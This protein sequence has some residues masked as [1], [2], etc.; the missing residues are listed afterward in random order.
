M[1]RQ[2]AVSPSP[3]PAPRCDDPNC[4]CRSPDLQWFT[5]QVL[6]RDANKTDYIVI[7]LVAG[8]LARCILGD[9]SDDSIDPEGVAVTRSAAT[10]VLELAERGRTDPW[11]NDP[12]AYGVIAT[13]VFCN[14]PSLLTWGGIS[15]HCTTLGVGF[16][17]PSDQRFAT[18]I[19]YLGAEPPPSLTETVMLAM[20]TAVREGRNKGEMP[21]LGKGGRRL[22]VI[23]AD[24]I[25]RQ[26]LAAWPE[27]L[28]AAVDDWTLP[29]L[30]RLALHNGM[31]GDAAIHYAM[32]QMARAAEGDAEEASLPPAPPH[33]VEVSGEAAAAESLVNEAV[34]EIKR[35]HDQHAA[36]QRERDTIAQRD[37]RLR[38]RLESLEQQL[39]DEREQ[40]QALERENA[41]LRDERDWFAERVAVEPALLDE[42]QPPPADAFSGRR[43]LFF[44][45]VEAGDARMA[46]AQGFWDLGA[47]QVDVY[48]TDK[49]RGP[50]AFPSDAI[51]AIDVS[52]MRHSTWN[53]I[54]DKAKSAGAWCYWGK[55]G[56]TMMARATAGAWAK[57]RERAES[58]DVA[59]G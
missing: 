20:V 35:L 41:E 52:L 37:A 58:T 27:I 11:Q 55:H 12:H 30:Q 45:G 54:L 48:W 6:R 4:T 49:T 13:F 28:I 31:A 42:A 3:A 50:D 47:A 22:R 18:A 34:T 2:D 15:Y 7:P 33:E 46:L 39:A 25:R 36:A 16:G 29:T 21:L 57:R 32:E 10:R 38:S 5:D 17:G 26:G 24:R 51:I 14:W 43:V 56:A 53:A 8:V 44:T 1:S 19:K 9:D 40:R 23:L 59:G